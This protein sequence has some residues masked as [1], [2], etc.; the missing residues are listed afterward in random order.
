MLEKF[1]KL[2]DKKKYRS[3]NF[4]HCV[5]IVGKLI[6]SLDYELNFSIESSRV[7]CSFPTVSAF[8]L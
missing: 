7:T 5:S 4:Q 6:L 3:K 1:R 2:I 8:M